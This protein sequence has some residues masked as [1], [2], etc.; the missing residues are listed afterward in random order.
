VGCSLLLTASKLVRRPSCQGMLDG[1]HWHRLSAVC[2]SCERSS[3]R[4]RTA[5]P[6]LVFKREASYGDE[7]QSWQT[8]SLCSP[9]SRIRRSSSV[10]R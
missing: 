5:T 8:G 7:L 6:K 10:H 4:P 3:Y 1:R 2:P 9:A